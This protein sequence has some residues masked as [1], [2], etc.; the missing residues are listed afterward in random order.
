MD[1]KNIKREFLKFMGLI[2]EE[3]STFVA[4]LSKEEKSRKGSLKKWSAK[5]VFSHL[6]FWGNHFNAQLSKAKEGGKGPTA[7]DYFDKVNDGVLYQHMEQLFDEALKEY[8]DSYETSKNLLNG[9]STDKLND[10]A[11]Y[12]YLDGRSIVDRAL[13][14]FGWHIAYHLSDY[15]LKENQTEKAVKLQE[16]YTEK[17]KLFPSWEAN[18][19]YNLACFYTQIGENK[20]AIANLKPAFLARPDLIEWSKKDSD[21]DPL[22]EEP[23]FKKLID[24]D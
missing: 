23:D 6:V 20:K 7:G 19:I 15:Y 14:T 12:E 13:G 3:V 17:L 11:I 2:E 5:D 4:G 9:Y 21:L 22:R 8:N 1:N 10:N 18:A 16:N 24:S